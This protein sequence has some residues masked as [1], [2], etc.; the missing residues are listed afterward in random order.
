MKTTVKSMNYQGGAELSITT[1]DLLVSALCVA[2]SATCVPEEPSGDFAFHFIPKYYNHS[3]LKGGS[4]MTGSAG[5][6]V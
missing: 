2:D 4:A 1:D 5:F 6:F 3:A